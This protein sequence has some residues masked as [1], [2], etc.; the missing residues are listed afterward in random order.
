M[1]KP[2]HNQL[3]AACGG[4][5]QD[6]TITHEEKRGTHISLFPNVPAKTCTTCREIWIDEEVLQQSER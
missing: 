4:E 1:T 5:L 2:S 3:C 6:I